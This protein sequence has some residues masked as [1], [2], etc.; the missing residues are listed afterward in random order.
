LPDGVIY[1]GIGNMDPESAL[2]STH[3]TYTTT[4]TTID[5]TVRFDPSYVR[6]L[7]GTLKVGQLVLNL[8]GFICVSVA[9]NSRA[10]NANWFSFVSMGGFWITLILLLLFL[11]HIIEKLHFIPWLLAETV[12][13]A[14]WTFIYFTA[15]TAVSSMS[16]Y[17]GVFIAA[18]VFGYI[19]MLV[20]GFDAY[21]KYISWKAG[22]LA[23]GNRKTT[24][25]TVPA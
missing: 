19:A 10:H 23:Q 9:R 2:P 8:L 18:A 15:A 16:N 24:T 3:R 4:T 13:C 25:T 17:E 6:S 20:Y 11:F 7:P 22:E 14:I 21:L 1:T 5:T 12:Y